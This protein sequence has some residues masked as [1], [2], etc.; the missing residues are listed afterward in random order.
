MQ[1]RLPCIDQEGLFG[2]TENGPKTT[3]SFNLSPKFNEPVLS[4]WEWM[5]ESERLLATK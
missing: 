2:Y 1:T 5:W 3:T 4:L